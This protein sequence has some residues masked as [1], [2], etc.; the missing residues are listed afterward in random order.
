M[1]TDVD[2]SVTFRERLAKHSQ[3]KRFVTS[4][5]IVLRICIVESGGPRS[6]NIAQLVPLN[7]KGFT[8]TYVVDAFQREYELV[9]KNASTLA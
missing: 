5:P 3:Y 7:R 9:A 2:S 4:D 1:C 8:P 6:G